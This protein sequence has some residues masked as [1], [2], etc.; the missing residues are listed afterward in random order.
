MDSLSGF[1]SLSPSFGPGCVFNLACSLVGDDGVPRTA[2]E[3]L[4]KISDSL[5]DPFI[6]PELGG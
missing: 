4:M 6:M 5:V 1:G 3:K 2:G